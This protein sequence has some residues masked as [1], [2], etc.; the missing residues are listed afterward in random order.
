MVNT[1][2]RTPSQQTLAALQQYLNHQ[3]T[4]QQLVQITETLLE[5][6]LEGDYRSEQAIA[7][8]QLREILADITAQWECLQ[9]NLR[10]SSA[11]IH[12]PEF[13]AEWI[14]DWLTQ[15]DAIAPLNQ[16][17]VESEH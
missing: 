1:T 11:S 5:S 10:E 17:L 7:S 9:G 8:I 4:S 12:S 14:D 6:L 2:Q 3:L 16:Q 15:I 13:P